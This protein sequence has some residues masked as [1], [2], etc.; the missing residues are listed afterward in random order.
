MTFL[1]TH[2]VL[3]LYGRK[4]SGLSERARQLVEESTN[5][6]I[7]PMVLL[8]LEYLNEIGRTTLPSGPVYEYLLEKIDLKVSDTSFAEIIKESSKLNWTR[9]PFDRIIV[10][11][12]AAEN[13][14]LITKDKSILENYQH[15]MW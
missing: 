3:W 5:L 1:D 12:A 15:A 4:G 6:L 10:G 9:D 14:I 2:V 13:A 11:N 7:S 8:E